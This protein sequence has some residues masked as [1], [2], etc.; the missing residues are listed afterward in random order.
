VHQHKTIPPNTAEQQGADLGGLVVHECLAAVP[1][2]DT[3]A[4]QLGAGFL[5][6][7]LGGPMEACLLPLELF[8]D[9]AGALEGVHASHLLPQLTG[10]ANDS[11]DILLGMLAKEVGC[12]CDLIRFYPAPGGGAVHKQNEELSPL[13]HQIL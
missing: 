1:A 9:C 8:N 6:S 12:S 7:Q 10:Q 13:I 11:L 3:L 4:V 2:P 5:T